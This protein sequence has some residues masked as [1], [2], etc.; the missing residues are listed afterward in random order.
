MGALEIGAILLGLMLVLLAG[1]L[2]IAIT[3]G[4]VAWAGMYFFTSSPPA[5]SLVT[6]LPR[7]SSFTV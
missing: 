3:L 2:W 6:S 1:G 7:N 4:V 5:L